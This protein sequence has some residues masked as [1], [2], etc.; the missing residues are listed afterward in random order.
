[1]SLNLFLDW[2]NPI[3][4]MNMIIHPVNILLTV[5]IKPN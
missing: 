1:M 5:S 3:Q 4:P 2:G